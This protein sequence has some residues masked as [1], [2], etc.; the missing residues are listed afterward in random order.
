MKRFYKLAPKVLVLVFLLSF[1]CVLPSA[2][3]DFYESSYN[4]KNFICRS[5]ITTDYGR[6][7]IEYADNT[8]QIEAEMTIK[9]RRSG[10]HGCP[11]SLPPIS[12]QGYSFVEIEANAHNIEYCSADFKYYIGI[13]NVY[14]LLGLEP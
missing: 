7:K 2:T 6:A 11:C 3:S 9:Y 14:S 5:T 10:Q 4:Y 8:V 13:S 12:A 1:V